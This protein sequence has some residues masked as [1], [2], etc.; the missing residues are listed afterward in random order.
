MP[1]NPPRIYVDCPLA[2]EGSVSF[3]TA[4]AHYLKNVLR[5]ESGDIVAVFNGR[6][7]EWHADISALGRKSAKATLAK[8]IRDQTAAHGPDLIFAPVKKSATD[9]IVAKAT[10]LG[11]DRLIPVLTEFTDTGRINIE[12]LRANAIEAAEQ[13]NR[14]DIPEISP[15]M[16]LPELI[17][18]WPV[19]RPLIVADETGTG[20]PILTALKTL[21]S[22]EAQPPAFVIGPQGGFSESELV[23]LRGLAFVTLVDLGPRILRAETAAAA[24]LTCWQACRGDWISPAGG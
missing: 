13:C 11:A 1:R 14:L 19:D 24:V 6:D 7:G 12:R 18:N 21:P 4:Q 15:A 3:D 23:F 10:E 8:Q 16:R 2:K 9:F 22:G 20:A 17:G 5:L